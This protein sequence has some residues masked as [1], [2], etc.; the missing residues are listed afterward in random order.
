MFSADAM[1]ELPLRQILQAAAVP[2]DSRLRIAAAGILQ[3]NLLPS[4]AETRAG[5]VT[6]V[7]GILGGDSPF[8][9]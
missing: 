2:A 4:L 9:K 6:K 1:P 8:G 3:I 7:K 5:N